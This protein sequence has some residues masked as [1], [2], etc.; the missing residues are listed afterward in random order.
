MLPE[1][2]PDPS[3]IWIDGYWN[4]DNRYREYTWVEGY[5]TVAPAENAYWIP[6]YWESFKNGYRWIDAHWIPQNYLPYFGYFSGRYDYYGRPVYYHRPHYDTTNGYVYQYDHNPNHRIE[7]YNS[8]ANFNFSPK[9]ERERINMNYRNAR[10]APTTSYKQAET[11][12]R[13]KNDYSTKIGY[14]LSS[15]NVNVNNTIVY[16][17]V[18]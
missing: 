15:K 10:S 5:W 12:I 1:T 2:A 6:G 18:K 3:S 8:S 4:W 13:N 16:N 7:G 17:S 9:K 11:Q 14:D